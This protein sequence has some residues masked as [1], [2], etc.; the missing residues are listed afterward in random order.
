M[1]RH[2]CSPLPPCTANNIGASQFQHAHVHTQPSRPAA[3]ANAN[4]PL[5]PISARC[6]EIVAPGRS[7]TTTHTCGDEHACVLV[8]PLLHRHQQH[9]HDFLVVCLALH[10]RGKSYGHGRRLGQR[11][12]RR[13]RT[14]HMAGD[15]CLPGAAPNPVG[16]Q[17]GDRA[18]RTGGELGDELHQVTSRLGLEG[19]GLE[20]Y[21][22]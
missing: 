15:K 3:H 13:Q 16:E 9:P 20:G 22:W 2:V 17:A 21:R 12:P 19:R 8:R 5:P 6:T 7:H 11:L 10:A 4:R 14:V 18:L 1:S